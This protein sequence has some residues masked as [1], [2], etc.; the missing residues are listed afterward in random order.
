MVV[1]T[2]MYVILLQRK[3]ILMDKVI[4]YTKEIG[5]NYGSKYLSA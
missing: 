2:M 5:V 4:M 3:N 1:L